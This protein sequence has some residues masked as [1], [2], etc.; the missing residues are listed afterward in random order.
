M[1]SATL[2]ILA[3][4][5][6]TAT[7]LVPVPQLLSPGD[8]QSGAAAIVSSDAAS[9]VCLTDGR[10]QRVDQSGHRLTVLDTT[11]AV[12][13]NIT[14]S[15]RTADSVNKGIF[16]RA[17]HPLRVTLHRSG[18]YLRPNQVV[19]GDGAGLLG[20]ALSPGFTEETGGYLFVAFI[21]RRN[22]VKVQVLSSYA[23]PGGGEVSLGTRKSKA[24]G[25][26]QPAVK[27]AHDIRHA[28]GSMSRSVVSVSVTT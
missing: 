9:Y 22:N 19:A 28:G 2:V 5:T 20:C 21:S 12:S 13:T 14:P 1:L 4:L 27:K 6:A 25:E 3:C 15:K 23:L 18:F 24:Q 7:A 16:R 17:F 8:G 10:V 26:Q 11:A